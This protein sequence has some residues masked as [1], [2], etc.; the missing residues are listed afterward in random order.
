MKLM[1]ELVNTHRTRM[2]VI[3]E[4]DWLPFQRRIV[5]IELTPD[6]IAAIAPR[7]LGVECGNVWLEADDA[8]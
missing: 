2:A 3:H 8:D 1:V 7:E 4:N 5:S 6:Q